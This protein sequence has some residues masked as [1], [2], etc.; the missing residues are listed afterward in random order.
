M[1]VDANLV[2]C[3]N[4][5]NL[6]VDGLQRWSL[7]L[8]LGEKYSLPCRCGNSLHYKMGQMVF[9]PLSGCIR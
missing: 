4:L 2:F 5:T 9:V 8:L 7:L 1:S 3:P 6:G